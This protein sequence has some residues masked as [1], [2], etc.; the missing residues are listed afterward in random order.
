MALPIVSDLLVHA[1]DNTTIEDIILDNWG[2]G[3]YIY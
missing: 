1:K 2:Y 3:V